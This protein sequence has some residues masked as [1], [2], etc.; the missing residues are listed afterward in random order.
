MASLFLIILA[1]LII[2]ELLKGLSANG[3]PP[4]L[5]RFSWQLD[6]A[7]VM[8]NSIAYIRVAC[9]AVLLF[10][11]WRMYPSVPDSVVIYGSVLF[12]IWFGVMW[13]FNFFWVGKHK[14]DELDHP[15]FVTAEENEV[16]LDSDVMGTVLDGEAKAYP[17]DMVAYHHRI[18]DEIA[19]HPIWVT[20]CAMCRSGRIYDRRFEGEV[21]DFSLIGAITYNAT[22][23][24]NQTRTWWRQETGEAVKGPLKGKVLEDMFVEHMSLRDWLTKHPDS[25]VLQREEK[26]EATYDWVRSIL[27]GKRWFPAWYCFRKLQLVAG[28]DVDGRARAYDRD[29]LRR[30]RVVNDTLGDRPIVVFSSEDGRTTLAYHRE[31]DGKTLEFEA[32]DGKFRDRSSSSLWNLFGTCEGGEMAGKT[33]SPIQ[34]RQQNIRSWK[35]FHPGTDVYPDEAVQTG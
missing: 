10:L 17:V 2:A 9:F 33:L 14:F 13:L 4:V 12:V 31:V 5:Q 25:R 3:T 34:V 20:Y 35:T 30:E 1:L 32:V 29:F 19:G 18:Q 6:L 23:R 24:D 15:R 7:Y 26:H 21:L 22:F 11:L 27:D 16:D 8:W 28:V